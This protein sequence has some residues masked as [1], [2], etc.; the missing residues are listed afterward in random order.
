MLLYNGA[1]QS[2]NAGV[3]VLR[4]KETMQFMAF[5][6]NTGAQLWITDPQPAW[7]MYSSG[8]EIVN[9]YTHLWWIRRTNICL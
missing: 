9:G 1:L 7:M 5:D 3:L 4:A 2:M 8:A 6:I